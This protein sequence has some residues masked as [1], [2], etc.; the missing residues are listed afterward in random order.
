MLIKADLHNHTNFSFDGE[1]T[2]QALVDHYAEQGFGAV[3]VTDHNSRLGGLA[4][5]ELDPPFQV[6]V[7]AEIKSRHGE[8]IGL[9]L[10]KDIEPG[11]SAVETAQAI[12][13]AGG[14]TL[15]PHPFLPLV[16][17]RMDERELPGLVA[18]LDLV[19]A[20][21]ARGDD[22]THDR[23]AV[24]WAR[25]SGIAM[26]AGSDAHHLGGIGTGYVLMEDFDGPQDFLEK[27]RNGSLVCARRTHLYRSFFNWIPG[28]VFGWRRIRKM[29]SEYKKDRPMRPL[30]EKPDAR[31]RPKYW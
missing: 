8:I 6:I 14:L 7:G 25:A 1:V 21:N 15:L 13:E 10:D 23:D 11:L 24:T 30:W 20:L 4:V 22:P 12:H 16:I 26:S 28:H 29:H 3:A 31:T 27:V 17:S 18:H 19:E 5:A 9:F 2:P